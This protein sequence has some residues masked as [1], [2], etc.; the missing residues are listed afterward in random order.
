MT[1]DHKPIRRVRIL[2]YALF[3]AFVYTYF[4]VLLSERLMAGTY[5][6]MP[7]FTTRFLLR[8]S[9]FLWSPRAF[10]LL[11]LADFLQQTMATLQALR[12]TYATS[13]LPY[14]VVCCC[15][16]DSG[17]RRANYFRIAHGTSH[18]AP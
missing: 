13:A 15:W 14:F 18:C 17:C 3:G 1:D 8:L 16:P 2:Q 4:G 6:L 7:A 10:H 11:A 12:I 9:T 5:A